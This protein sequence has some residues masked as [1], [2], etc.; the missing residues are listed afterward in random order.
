MIRRRKTKIANNFCNKE[1]YMIILCFAT[2][3]L[4]SVLIFF[5]TAVLLCSVSRAK[6]LPG[7]AI[8]CSIGVSLFYS[9]YLSYTSYETAFM[10][11]VSVLVALAT[12]VVLLYTIK[13]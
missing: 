5:A 6:R 12:H 3:I 13:G 8:G 4:F 10:V 2:C 11:T 1:M 9:Q 7:G